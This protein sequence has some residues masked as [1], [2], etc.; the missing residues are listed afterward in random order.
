MDIAKALVVD[1]SKVVQFK[2][3]RMLEA[4]GMAVDTAASGLEALNYLK[5]HA[6]HVIFMDCMMPDM[7]GYEAT[8]RI[9]ELVPG[10]PPTCAQTKRS[11][12]AR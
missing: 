2:L 3:K 11:E 9:L 12:T 1:D 10:L 5:N 6:P 4:R 7:D 8:R